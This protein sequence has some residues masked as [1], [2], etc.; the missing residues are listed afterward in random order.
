MR[1]FVV[2]ALLLASGCGG[3]SSGLHAAGSPPA[4]HMD[5]L[6]AG[7]LPVSVQTD[8]QMKAAGNSGPSS[9]EALRP[10]SC[11]VSGSRVTAS[12]GIVG[13]FLP[14]VYARSGDVVELYVFTRPQPGY[15]AGIQLGLLHEESAGSLTGKRWR[16][17]VPL[18]SSLGRPARCVVAAQPT[19]D[20]QLAPSAY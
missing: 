3:G 20:E 11:K 12:G 19:H 10:Q 5:S 17:T 4:A 13:G 7:S 15:S 8:A 16:A 18:D 1:R 2:G 9:S 14:Q 6:T